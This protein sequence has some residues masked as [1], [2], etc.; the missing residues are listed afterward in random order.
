MRKQ[1][2][3]ER[4]EALAERASPDTAAR[5]KALVAQAEIR[6]MA[7]VSRGRRIRAVY[8]MRFWALWA[9]RA[10]GTVETWMRSD[11]WEIAQ[12]LQRNV[13]LPGLVAVPFW[14]TYLLDGL[15][16]PSYLAPYPHAHAIRPWRVTLDVWGLPLSTFADRVELSRTH[17]Y[18]HAVDSFRLHGLATLAVNEFEGGYRE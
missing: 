10:P 14:A 8:G 9:E 15:A 12:V 11:D 16:V 2:I 7:P 3:C 4:L 1:W 6:P 17:L 5:Y 13:R 18:E